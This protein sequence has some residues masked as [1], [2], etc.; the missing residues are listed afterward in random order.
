MICSMC[1]ID[2][3]ESA[4]SFKANGKR[5]RSTCNECFNTLTSIHRLYTGSTN[6]RK[7]AAETSRKRWEYQQT[8]RGGY[9]KPAAV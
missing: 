8:G 4:F 5:R 2:K 3:P 7:L 9:P 1:E 6:A